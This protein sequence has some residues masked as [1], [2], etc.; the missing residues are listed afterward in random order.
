[1][2]FEEYG[3]GHGSIKTSRHH[4][5]KSVTLFYYVATHGG[6]IIPGELIFTQVVLFL[7]ETGYKITL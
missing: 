1:V 5:F 4:N 2:K 7:Q 6:R 3:V